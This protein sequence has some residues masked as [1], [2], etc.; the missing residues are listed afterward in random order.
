MRHLSVEIVMVMRMTVI[1]RMIMI[2]VVM[3]VVVRVVRM[4]R[5]D[6]GDDDLRARLYPDNAAPREL[7]PSPAIRTPET[8]PSQG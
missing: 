4:I 7:S 5:H 1:M 2:A 8:T 3:V 6:G